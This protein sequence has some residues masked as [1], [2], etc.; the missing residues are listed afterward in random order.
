MSKNLIETI[1][2]MPFNAGEMGGTTRK[3][4]KEKRLVKLSKVWGVLYYSIP[5][6]LEIIDT[7]VDTAVF[8]SST[9]C[10]CKSNY[11]YA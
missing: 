1:S 7:R 11:R 5:L 2:S 8:S 9:N 4:P 3:A 10:N 6:G